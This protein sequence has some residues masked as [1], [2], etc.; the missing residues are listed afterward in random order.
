MQKKGYKQTPEHILKKALAKRRGR[1]F[2]CEICNNEFWRYPSAIKKGDCRFCSRECYCKWQKGKKKNILTKRNITGENNPNW[3]GGIDYN[4]RSVRRSNEYKEWR[5]KVFERDNWT[6][7]KCG[8][9]SKSKCYI[10]I[11]AHHIKPFCLF[12]EFRLVVENGITL[13]K[14]CHNKEPKGRQIYARF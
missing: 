9:K 2:R 8:T 14:E 7:K 6:C 11:E 10:K 4:N 12:P 3:K 5:S 1:Y 13:C